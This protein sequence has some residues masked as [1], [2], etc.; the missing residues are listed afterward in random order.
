MMCPVG[1]VAKMIRMGKSTKD[2]LKSINKTYGTL[3]MKAHRAYPDVPADLIAKVIALESSGRAWI[4]SPDKGMGLMQLM[5]GTARDL[6]VINPYNPEENIMGGAKYLSQ[7]EK[8]YQGD[9]D[10]VLGAY[11]AGQNR[12]D[13][14]GLEH[15]PTITKTYIKRYHDLDNL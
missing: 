12:V 14:S 3:I 4:T 5:P 7:L 9:T 1:G 10:K 2:M 8:H 11:N 13:R 6:G 15:V